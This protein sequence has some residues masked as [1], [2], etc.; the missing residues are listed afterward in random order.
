MKISELKN[1]LNSVSEDDDA[2][3]VIFVSSEYSCNSHVVSIDRINITDFRA[4]LIPKS[5][6]KLC[7]P[8]EPAPA[9]PLTEYNKI[10]L[11][12]DNLKRELYNILRF[13]SIDLLP[14]VDKNHCLK[15][16]R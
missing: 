11:E 15:Y 10:K 9:V 7:S 5:K 16:H 12:R 8:N 1:I 3:F 6:L 13:Q 2:E 14:I 4:E